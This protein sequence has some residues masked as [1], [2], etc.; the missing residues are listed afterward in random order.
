MASNESQV[1]RVRDVFAQWAL[2]GRAEGMERGHGPAARQA[3]ERLG[4]GDS[5]AYL[6]IGCGNGYSLAW[7]LEKGLEAWGI[8]V[9]REMIDLASGKYGAAAQLI[10]GTFP[11]PDLPSGHFDGIFSMEVFY[12]L[13][14]LDE[15]L[16]AAHG[17]LQSGGRF[18][19]IVD[20][21]RENPD[22]HSWPE[23]TGVD[24]TLWSEAEWRDGFA[25]A[26]FVDIEQDRLRPPRAPGETPTWKHEAGSLL[27]LGRRA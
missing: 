26:G 6:D 11:H 17:L 10:T 16:R 20:F 8:D 12:Y 2:S 5:G 25:R 22:S 15:G 18:A 7:A 27:T 3:F 19:C 23:D 9:A 14:S 24:M 13:P 21:Y 4:L 1:D